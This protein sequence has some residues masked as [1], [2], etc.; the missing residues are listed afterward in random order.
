[1]KDYIQNI[2]SSY[3]KNHCLLKRI[4]KSKVSMFFTFNNYENEEHVK[5]ID[6]HFTYIQTLLI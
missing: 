3:F 4:S 6:T 2:L 5:I 1:M